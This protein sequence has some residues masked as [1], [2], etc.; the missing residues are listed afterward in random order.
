MTTLSKTTC[1]VAC[2]V[3]LATGCGVRTHR[4][5]DW[6][7]L[8]QR[9]DTKTLAVPPGVMYAGQAEGAIGGGSHP[10]TGSTM[11]FLLDIH[12]LVKEDLFPSGAKQASYERLVRDMTVTNLQDD[13]IRFYLRVLDNCGV[14]VEWQRQQYGG[15]RFAHNGRFRRFMGTNADVVFST[16]LAPWALSYEKKYPEQGPW[17]LVQMTIIPH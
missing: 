5:I 11:A 3:L 6:S 17:M 13:V 15:A 12:G 10:E 16:R 4:K 7:L 8:Q 14:D 2:V 1:A 9:F